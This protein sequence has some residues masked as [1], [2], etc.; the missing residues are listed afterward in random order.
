M[1][2]EKIYSLDELIKILETIYEDRNL[3]LVSYT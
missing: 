3:S 1:K 2:N